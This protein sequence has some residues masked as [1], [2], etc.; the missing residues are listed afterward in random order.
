[1][2]TRI[3]YQGSENLVITG[4]SMDWNEDMAS[5]IVLLPKD[6]DYKSYM[7][8]NPISWKSKYGSIVTFGYHMGA[9]DGMNEKGLAVNALYLAESNYSN[10]PKFQDLCI[11][12]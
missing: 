3:L 9:A 4:R 10:N 12:Q 1:M 11:V 5:N 6:V 7:G 2:C 8:K